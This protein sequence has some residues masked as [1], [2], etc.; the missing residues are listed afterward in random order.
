MLL[1]VL[2]IEFARAVE[3]EIDDVPAVGIAG[4]IRSTWCIGLAM[5]LGRDVAHETVAA[6][7]LG[8]LL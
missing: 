6:D 7:D 3:Y 1:W 5:I 4:D 8:P 2:G